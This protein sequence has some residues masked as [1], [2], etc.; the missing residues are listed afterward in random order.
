MR[1]GSSSVTK[2]PASSKLNL[3]AAEWSDRMDRG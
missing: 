3:W 1:E 2:K